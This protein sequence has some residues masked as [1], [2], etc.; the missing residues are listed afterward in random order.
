MNSVAC[1]RR[2]S[3]PSAPVTGAG[4]VSDW[5]DPR[6]IIAA[7]RGRSAGNRSP[8]TSPPRCARQ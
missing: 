1:S 8:G 2:L 7:E 4:I 6:W 5:T 3:A